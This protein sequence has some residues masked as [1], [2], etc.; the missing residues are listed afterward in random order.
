MEPLFLYVYF[1]QNIYDRLEYQVDVRLQLS[2]VKPEIVEIWG[3]GV[4]NISQ[5]T[6]QLRRGMF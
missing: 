4:V 5:L 1:N 2:P 6:S 3:G